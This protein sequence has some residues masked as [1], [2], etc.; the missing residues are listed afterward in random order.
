MRPRA[1]GLS[2]EATVAYLQGLLA[3]TDYAE[4]EPRLW[5]L[6]VQAIVTCPLAQAEPKKP[7]GC[8]GAQRG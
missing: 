1:A 6:M 4:P 7:C 3:A 5:S 2:P 8:G